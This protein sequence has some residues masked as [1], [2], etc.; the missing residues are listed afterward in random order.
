MLNVESAKRLLNTQKYLDINNF[1][2]VINAD[3]KITE[4]SKI[5]KNDL[6]YEN[7]T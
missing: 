7:S 3:I 1:M 4:L 5:L 2:K 6:T